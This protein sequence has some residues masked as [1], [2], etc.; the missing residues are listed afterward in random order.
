MQSE[1]GEIEV[2]L[3]PDDDSSN[4]GSPGF[5]SPIKRHPLQLHGNC[6]ASA[7]ES[8]T[9]D[10]ADSIASP[11]KIKREVTSSCSDMSSLLM[12][13]PPRLSSSRHHLDPVDVESSK[14]A[15]ISATPDFGP[16]GSNRI[17][18]E[19]LDQDP[20]GESTLFS[21]VSVKFC[22]H[23]P[24]SKVGTDTNYTSSSLVLKDVGRKKNK[25]RRRFSMK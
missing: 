12:S 4:G 5:N 21:C 17:Q 3:C 7:D 14:Y 19:T 15:L 1:R 23:G 8:T 16:M 18:L 2:Y 20:C 22:Y 13:P 10:D 9:T 25:R 6:D 11:V 24:H